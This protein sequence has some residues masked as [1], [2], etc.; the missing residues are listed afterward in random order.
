MLKIVAVIVTHVP[1]RGVPPRKQRAA[2]KKYTVGLPMERIALDIL[3]P[4]P[5]TDYGN[6]YI[7]VVSDYFTKWVEAF[8]MPDQEASTVAELLVKEVVC[9]F[10]VPLI[11]H[12]DQGRNFESAVFTEVCELLGMQ[13]TR[14]TAYH[15]Q[16]D[17]MVE[18]FN[19]TLV[20]PAIK[21]CE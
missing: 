21:I 6:R 16:S 2:M 11:I 8:P 9:R 17:G 7:L 1:R 19:R 4:L 10:G 13:K 14:T 15:P 12:S 5:V 18:R 3:G 20:E